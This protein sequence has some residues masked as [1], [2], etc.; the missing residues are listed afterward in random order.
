MLNSVNTNFNIVYFFAIYLFVIF[1]LILNLF[2]LVFGAFLS[3]LPMA[4]LSLVLYCVYSRKSWAS[5]VVKIW[6]SLLIISGAAMWAAVFF[7]GEKYLHSTSNAAIKT[8]AMAFGLYFF[9]FA[10][11]VLQPK[12]EV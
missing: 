7:G 11:Q 8:F 5:T 10:N 2:N 3:I 4:T 12:S 6:S 1:S 9:T